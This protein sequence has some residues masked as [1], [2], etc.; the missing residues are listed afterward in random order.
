MYSN[1]YSTLIIVITFILPLVFVVHCLCLFCFVLIFCYCQ[2]LLLL[3]YGKIVQQLATRDRTLFSSLS[4][5]Q[6]NEHARG[7]DQNYRHRS[8]MKAIRMIITI[9]VTFFVCWFP[10]QVFYFIIW[11]QIPDQNR[12]YTGQAPELFNLYVC[13][14]FAFH[15]LSMAHSIMNPFIYCL[16]CENFQVLFY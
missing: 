5:S 15:F 6:D 2:I 7:T 16:M 14:F 10:I 4:G 12:S 11:T 1:L 3:I 8:S 13:A 9:V